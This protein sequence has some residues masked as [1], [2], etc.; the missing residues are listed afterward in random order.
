[1]RRAVED[2]Q[3]IRR[4]L[5]DDLTPEEQ[6]RLEERL[7]DD[8]DDFFEQLQLVEAEL[9]DDYVTGDLSDDERARFTE[10]FPST[11]GRYRQ[12]MFTELLRGHFAAAAPL[13][14]TLTA[15]AR[16]LSSWPQKL[17][18]LLGLDRPAVGFAL[19]CGLLV[20]ITAAVLL[21]LSAWR[22]SRR[23]DELRAQQ[24][25]TPINADAVARLQQQLAEE[26]ARRESATEELARERERRAGPEQ[27]IAWK[28]EG[29]RRETAASSL[30][31]SASERPTQH[32][33][34][35]TAGAV[36][37]LM[38]TSGTI[39]EAGEYKTL[40]LTP[41][42]AI[43]RLRLDIGA[44]DYKSLRVALQD[45]DGK[46]LLTR[47][48]LRPKPARGGRVIVFD[49]PVRFLA[50]GGDFQV[51]LSG[52]TRENVIEGI[53]RYDFRVVRR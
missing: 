27:D 47:D 38:L 1:V 8:K 14:K 44:D 40:T 36:L 10:S 48:G 25:P 35:S 3:T 34:R 46:S 42:A 30:T 12:L 39:R 23:L 22:L 7:L 41:K 53:S 28:R 19:A 21:G 24:S 17:S 52:V 31:G 20:A 9:A 13:K 43:V 29:G 49:V 51:Q 45:S 50:G 32:A 33:Q 11:P 2:E 16:P 26:R 4:Y 37:S 18:M 15:K 5:L 6:R